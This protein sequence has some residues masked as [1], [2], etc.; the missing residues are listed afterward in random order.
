MSKNPLDTINREAPKSDNP[1]LGLGD[2][3]SGELIELFQ[4]IED[5]MRFS[6]ISDKESE[7][8]RVNIE[9]RKKILE[10]LDELIEGKQDYLNEILSQI[11]L[12]KELS[13]TGKSTLGDFISLHS[14]GEGD[15]QQKLPSGLGSQDSDTIAI[16]Q[17][18]R[19]SFENAL[20]NISVLPYD[21]SSSASPYDEIEEDSSL[22]PNWISDDLRNELATINGMIDP[23]KGWK[24][25]FEKLEKENQDLRQE[26]YSAKKT[27]EKSLVQP[28]IEAFSS[29]RR[30]SVVSDD[31]LTQENQ[32]LHNDVL[33]LK[34]QILAKNREVDGLRVELSE[35]SDPKTIA[36]LRAELQE[37]KQKLLAEIAKN[38]RLETTKTSNTS[39]SRAAVLEREM[40]FQKAQIASLEEE[41]KQFEIRS[42]NTALLISLLETQIADGPKK[43]ADFQEQLDQEKLKVATESS[44]REKAEKDKDVALAK[45]DAIKSDLEIKLEAA[46]KEKDN[47]KAESSVVRA[48]N[49]Q[50]VT[51]LDEAIREGSELR[52]EN[53]LLQTTTDMLRSSENSLKTNL[54]T[55]SQQL[56]I[57]AAENSD[58]NIRLQESE[59]AKEIFDKDNSALRES[60]IELQE[61]LYKSVLAKEAAEKRAAEKEGE[62]AAA[63]K[64]VSRIQAEKDA[65]LQAQ[66]DAENLSRNLASERDQA[67]V[68]LAEMSR[69]KDAEEEAKR[70]AEARA[71]NAEKER[72]DAV[73][74]KISAEAASELSEKARA[75]EEAAR[76]AAEARESAKEIERSNAIE[77]RRLALESLR[78]VTTERDGAII[79]AADKERLRS[80]AEK[81]R[82]EEEAAKNVAL[83]A[84]R[85]AENLSRSL[86]S[87]RDIA[88]RDK[89]TAT[90]ALADMTSLKNDAEE[91]TVLIAKEKADLEA[92][93]RLALDDV[94]AKEVER[95]AAVEAERLALEREAVALKAKKEAEKETNYVTRRIGI[96]NTRLGERADQRDVAIADALNRENQRAA[97]EAARRAVEAREA[98]TVGERDNARNDL[99]IRTAERDAARIDAANKDRLRLDAERL[100]TAEENDKNNALA[101][102]TASQRNLLDLQKSS[103]HEVS[104]ARSQRDKALEDIERLQR[105]LEKQSSAPEHKIIREFEKSFQPNYSKAS[106]LL[107]GEKTEKERKVEIDYYRNHRHKIYQDDSTKL[108]HTK[109]DLSEASDEEVIREIAK[110]RERAIKNSLP[111]LVAKLI[112]QKNKESV[113]E[114][115]SRTDIVI[116]LSV[117]NNQEFDQWK[118]ENPDA[119]I[120]STFFGK[121]EKGSEA[122]EIRSKAIENLLEGI[123]GYAAFFGVDDAKVLEPNMRP[124]TSPQFISKEELNL[125][126]KFRNKTLSNARA[127]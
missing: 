39:E 14:F 47:T 96:L 105:R 42:Q 10:S 88:N 78:I 92:A 60:L 8:H 29:R 72:G 18:I 61:N 123:K 31:F 40:K 52:E 62:T 51:E 38:E 68:D 114:K 121:L 28:A 87:E 103:S 32:K 69:L 17:K 26:L 70:L 45:A 77:E 82:D 56:L 119:N 57:Q 48:E 99:G 9:E 36:E 71:T 101:R 43:L 25:I 4:T 19:Q 93:R 33:E 117:G 108:A 41:K 84:K 30:V 122:Q 83:K 74:A 1:P 100:K 44:L 23:I 81:L 11:D 49:S 22:F 7:E 126:K 106:D 6:D 3:Y 104:V 118:K 112:G 65:A 89:A 95:V 127:A 50:L 2:A 20:G 5:E 97:E 37:N 21:A 67:M 24:S 76:R 109:I 90:H 116:A 120:A 113:I 27:D 115:L 54:H 59:K 102:L 73:T 13:G 55:Q 64:E 91:A 111:K 15:N 34:G 16:I 125:S 98:V 58:L 85:D 107:F 35:V 86:A 124:N 79:E 75:D 12:S 66:V 80:D 53:K 63:L 46:L 94:A 110:D